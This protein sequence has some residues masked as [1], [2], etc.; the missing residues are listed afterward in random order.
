MFLYVLYVFYVYLSWNNKAYYAKNVA[1][2]PSIFNIKMGP[3]KLIDF[4]NFLKCMWYD[5]CHNTI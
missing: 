2:L 3:H 5:S 1:F 4:D